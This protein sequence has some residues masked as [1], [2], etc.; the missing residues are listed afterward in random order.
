M[1]DFANF[2]K[3]ESGGQSP[4]ATKQGPSPHAVA[5]KRSDAAWS[6]SKPAAVR[7]SGG[8]GRSK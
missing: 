7:S 6:V 5:D 2:A 1:S 3:K 8:G 4:S